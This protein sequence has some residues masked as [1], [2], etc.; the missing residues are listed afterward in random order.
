MEPRAERLPLEGLIDIL[1]VEDDAPTRERLSDALAAASDFAVTS[2]ANLTD[3]LAK[4]D[5]GM[6]RI[7]LTDLQLPDGHGI[8]LI[9]R[10]RRDSPGTDIM[11]ISIL[12]DEESVIAA[13]TAGATGYLLKD[14]FQT[15][16]AATVRELALGHSPISASIARY[17]VRRTQAS[18]Q[19]GPEVERRP[20]LNTARLT[21]REIDILWGIAKGFSYA[22]IAEHLGLSR[23]TVPGHIKSI[24]RKLEVNTRGEAVFEAVQQG[25]IRL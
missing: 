4:L 1:L 18:L 13:I 22:D 20:T 3:A 12:G 10:V 21:A 7:L 11:V 24:Y 17:I 25:L 16:V 6:P 9:R 5:E 14:A 23:Q 8:E 2:V 19:P 15:D